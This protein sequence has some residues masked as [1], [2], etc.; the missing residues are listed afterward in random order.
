MDERTVNLPGRDEQKSAQIFRQ[1]RADIRGGESFLGEGAAGRRGGAL[2][3]VAFAQGRGVLPQ[4]LD[5]RGP[6]AL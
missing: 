2:C 6:A 5:G 1:V 3:R 4:G